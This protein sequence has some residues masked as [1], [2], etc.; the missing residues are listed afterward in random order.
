MEWRNKNDNTIEKVE[1][2]IFCGDIVN[3]DDINGMVGRG[4]DAYDLVDKIFEL[5]DPPMYRGAIFYVNLS[6]PSEKFEICSSLLAK[7]WFQNFYTI[8]MSVRRDEIYAIVI[9]VLLKKRF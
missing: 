8:S 9:D 4:H 7:L 6:L 3:E 1:V 5:Y 2:N